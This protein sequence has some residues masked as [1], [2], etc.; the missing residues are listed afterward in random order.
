MILP[1][2]HTRPCVIPY[3][4]QIMGFYYVMSLA[5]AK[6]IV[7]QKQINKR[8]AKKKKKESAPY[9]VENLSI[10]PEGKEVD[11]GIVQIETAWVLVVGKL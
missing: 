9:R 1:N 11:T 6:A 7:P 10:E 4:Y 3:A 2:T 8:K 5:I